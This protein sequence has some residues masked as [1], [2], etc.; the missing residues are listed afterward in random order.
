MLR[1]SVEVDTDGAAFVLVFPKDTNVIGGV[2][3][4]Q[5]I[6][7]NPMVKAAQ[8][9]ERP[10]SPS[11]FNTLR[12]H[13]FDRLRDRPCVQA[14][15]YQ[16]VV[17][18]A[19]MH[20]LQKSDFQL[21]SFPSLDGDE[22]FLTVGMEEQ[23]ERVKRLAQR[24]AYKVALKSSA[25]ADMCMDPNYNVGQHLSDFAGK[26]AAA[27]SVD[28]A[29]IGAF[30]GG[31]DQLGLA[32]GGG[33]RQLEGAIGAD[34]ANLQQ[35]LHNLKGNIGFKVEKRADVAPA[36]P[37]F[38]GGIPRD[39]EG[40]L[41]PAYVAYSPDLAEY[42]SEFRHIDVLRLLRM[43]LDEF[44]NIEE[45][46]AQQII[47][48]YF[49]AG[50]PELVD[51]FNEDFCSLKYLFTLPDLA[52]AQKVRLYFGEHIVFFFCWFS[53]YVHWLLYLAMIGFVCSVGVHLIP[54]LHLPL[55]WDGLIHVFMAF[56][57]TVWGVLFNARF[58]AEIRANVKRWGMKDWVGVE[59]ERPEWEPDQPESSRLLKWKRRLL[60]QL[61]IAFCILFASVIMEFAL[62]AMEQRKLGN[63]L[64][65]KW[66]NI[67][68]VV[69][70]HTFSLVWAKLAPKLCNHYN[71][72]TDAQYN[73]A[74][75]WMVA[76]V[77]IFV[78][79]FPFIDIIFIQN[80]THP[81]CSNR[82]DPLA[83]AA[84]KI[85]GSGTSWPAGLGLELASPVVKMFN[86]TL[87]RTM[88]TSLDWLEEYSFVID[89]GRCIRGCY[90]VHCDKVGLDGHYVCDTNCTATLESNMMTVYISHMVMTL[91][92][93]VGVPWLLTS[94][95]VAKE[96]NHANNKHSMQ[97]SYDYMP[98]SPITEEGSGVM[99]SLV[100]FQAKCAKL[101]PY[102]YSSWGGSFIDDF[103][104]VAI[105]FAL[106]TCFGMA[107]PSV[108]IL[109]FLGHLV[110][111]RLM[112][113]RMSNMTCRPFPHGGENVGIWK[114]I[115]NIIGQA[116]VAINVGMA[117]F[118][119]NP[120]RSWDFEHQLIAFLALEHSLILLRSAVSRGSEETGGDD[121]QQIE[122]FNNRTVAWVADRCSTALRTMSV[123]V[124]RRK[125]SMYLGEAEVKIGN[126][127]LYEQLEQ[128]L[129]QMPFKLG[130]D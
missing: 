52:S 87:A 68:T 125:R 100:Q 47:V 129:A 28:Q 107:V 44:F 23:G 102:K 69:L 118:C 82:E 93:G 29:L 35:R 73:E 63:K 98:T 56:V 72:R 57:L 86:G 95:E 45:L 33:L 43:H 5:A 24:F 105:G 48:N 88:P 80:Y 9:F 108:P 119:M 71:Y 22:D 38:R 18:A 3:D 7:E 13:G 94:R 85:Y 112:A 51:E 11:S 116:A 10:R 113:F 6:I 83:G 32:V 54:V 77:R 84:W 96:V 126:H 109:A 90:P 67:V 78:A 14:W 127:F 70:M 120:M 39:R 110:E 49:C 74:L 114:V 12:W 55:E 65:E 76:S 4:P 92:L 60:N 121:E 81:T 40:Q 26:L 75:T 111:Y 34:N 58:D 19:V 117:V 27:A 128:E 115:F 20:L 99:Y 97:G 15:E 31:I 59:V 103:V 104:E 8:I 41:V 42:L 36:D 17:R 124:L 61:P 53:L 91:L 16:I 79:L 122:D 89:G 50:S 130:T 62:F 106:L 30:G 1:A 64:I 46:S 66:G 25:Y 123:P 37:K 101:A 21:R 2:L